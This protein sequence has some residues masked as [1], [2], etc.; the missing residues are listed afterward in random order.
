MAALANDTTNLD[1]RVLGR[2]ANPDIMNAHL[3]N[4]GRSIPI[5]ILYD[6]TW[7]ERGWWGPRP[8]PL[9]TWVL[10]VGRTLVKE[11]KY[12]EIRSWYAHDR[13]A[14]TLR[15]IADL[16]VQADSLGAAR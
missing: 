7:N 8:A 4:G 13:G 15:E 2:D 14:T 16:I 3:T 1:L 11:E 9:Q 6:E 5:A 10:A 12:R